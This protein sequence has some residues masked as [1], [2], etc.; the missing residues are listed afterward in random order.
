MSQLIQAFRGGRWYESLDT[1]EVADGLRICLTPEIMLRDDARKAPAT[2]LDMPGTAR[3]DIL[4]RA[5]SSFRTGAPEVGGIGAQ[6]PDTFA[7]SL[8]EIAGL[9]EPLVWRWCDLLAT[10]IE[11]LA[12]A[13]PDRHSTLVWLPGNTFTC[14]VAVAEAVLRGSVL[15]VRPSTREPLSAARFVAALLEAGWPSHRIRFC[16]TRTGA[17]DTLLRVTD[18]QIVYGGEAVAAAVGHMSTVDL[19]G[20]GRACAVIAPD[21]DPD[22]TAAWLAGLVAA[23]SGRFCTNVCTVAC[24]GDPAPVAGRL[25]ELLDGIEL[26]PADQRWPVGWVDERTAARTAEFVTERVAA[27]DTFVTSRELVVSEG[28]RTFLSPT[29]VRLPSPAGHPLVGCEL[30]FPF[31]SVVAVDEPAARQLMARSRFVYTAGVTA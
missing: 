8:G 11:E 18:R 15:V 16:P 17:L 7:A 9:P 1:A 28:G 30:P 24:L 19:R 27:D 14:L 22:D 23:D 2:E 5:V 20:P 29:L 10:S 21:A 6:D 31:A 25:G 12:D 26:T 3:R 4:R 13:A